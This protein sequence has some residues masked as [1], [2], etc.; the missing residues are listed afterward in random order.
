MITYLAPSSGPTATK[1]SKP[2]TSISGVILTNSMSSTHRPVSA[3]AD[4][5]PR[6]IDGSFMSG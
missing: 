5:V 2:V 6:I 4:L 3:R 1:R